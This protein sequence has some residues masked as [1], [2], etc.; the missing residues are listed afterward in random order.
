MSLDLRGIVPTLDELD[1]IEADPEAIDAMLDAFL[2]DE[3]LQE[4]LVD[5]L[6]EFWLTRVDSFFLDSNAYG[7][8]LEVEQPFVHA[9][10]E[11]PLRLMAWIMATDQS[12][13]Q[14]VLSSNTMANAM[15]ADIW[16]VAY[17]P[18]GSDWQVSAYTDGRPALG[19]LATNGLWWR[20]DT[21]PGNLNRRRA[22]A[23]SRLL[24][25]EDF[26]S[27]PVDLSEIDI[28]SEDALNNAT[29]SNPSC[30]TCHSSLDPLASSLFGFWPLNRADVYEVTYYHPEREQVGAYYLGSEPAW[31][32][33]PLSDTSDLG[34]QIAQDV[35]FRRCAVQTYASLLWRRPITL[36]DFETISDVL[37]VFEAADLSTWT[38]LTELLAT[39]EYRVG[40]L[41]EPHSQ[42]QAKRYPSRRMMSDS[43]LASAIVDLTGFRWTDQGLDLLRND[44]FGYRILAGGV[45]GDSTT[46]PSVA[47]TLTRSL[48]LRRLAQAAASQVVAEDLESTDPR[49]LTWVGR[50]TQPGD[51]AFESQ[52]MALRRQLHGSS[53]AAEE[54]AADLA[55]WQAVEEQEGAQI[56]W[57]S[58]ISV[59]IRDPLFWLY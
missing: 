59:H 57:A 1:Q 46:T 40:E 19:V 34:V 21:S 16:P 31:F 6:A 20:Y 28:S 55:L 24:L 11:E 30:L 39:P 56:A 50:D 54:L 13:G 5:L 15:L 42:A 36:D 8:E 29:R 33:M 4:R 7:L 3:R 38:L 12:Y 26:L 17:D 48:V 37:A 10:G 49:L 51:P 9:I 23:V 27:R 47:P 32:G 2:R 43:Q 22:S 53:G 14:I 45:D 18:E 52:L 58:L 35:R 25:C 44:E 41:G